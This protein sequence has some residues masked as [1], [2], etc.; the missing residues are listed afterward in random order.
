V[1][2]LRRL[3]SG[4]KKKTRGGLPHVF[5]LK[6]HITNERIGSHRTK[7]N[8]LKPCPARNYEIKTFKNKLVLN[9]SMCYAC[10]EKERVRMKESLQLAIDALMLYS[11]ADIE[12]EEVTK[13][14]K[15]ISDLLALQKMF[16]PKETEVSEA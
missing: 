9:R 10:F 8:I 13:A 12:V 4:H 2:V 11:D 3:V 6:A 14:E 1:A 16:Y 5:F 15:A 7:N